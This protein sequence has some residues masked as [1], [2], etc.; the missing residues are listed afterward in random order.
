R[1]AGNALDTFH[2]ADEP[3][4]TVGR[5]G[6]EPDTAVAHDDRGDAVPDRRREQRVPRDLTVVVRVY[7][8]ET[9]RDREAVGV[10]LLAPALLDV[11]DFSDDPTVDRDV[12]GHR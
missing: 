2:E 12:G 7:I 5:G 4:V 10:E 1:R 6:R 8:D 3:V 9:G 11:A